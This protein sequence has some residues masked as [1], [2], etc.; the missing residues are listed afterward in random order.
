[1]KDKN[2]TTSQADITTETPSDAVHP[3]PKKPK[4]ATGPVALTIIAAI[5]LGGGAMWYVQKNQDSLSQHYGSQLSLVVEQSK[6]NE[7]ATQHA[8]NLMKNQAQQIVQLRQEL[9]Q[10]KD[11]IDDLSVALQTISE[12]GSDLMLL[13]DVE[14]LVILAQQQLLIGGNL[15]NAIV[16]LET[17]Q[18]RLAQ[19]DRQSLALLMQT[20][21]GDLD[22]LRTAQVVDVSTLTVQLDRLGNLL[23]KA[24]LYVPDAK[25][26][27]VNGEIESNTLT[28]PAATPDTETTAEQEQP[29]WKRTLSGAVDLTQ[30]G[31]QTISQDLGQFVSVRRVDDSA[32]LLMSPD[33]AER[34]RDSLSLRITMAQLALMTKQPKIWQDEMARI[35]EAI[36][37]RFDPSLAMTQRALSLAT[38][39]ADTEI[40][41]KLPTIDNTLAAIERLKQADQ[42]ELTAPEDLTASPTTE[43]TETSSNGAEE[44]QGSSPESTP[45]SAPESTDKE[46]TAVESRDM[47][48]DTVKP[49]EEAFTTSSFVVSKQAA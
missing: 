12:S 44:T 1:M 11:Q 20:M 5:V 9:A 22:R 47:P 8:L 28:E 24:P 7:Q 23:S 25:N 36:E 16:S 13:N 34:F 40:D 18:A 26:D 17:A 3:A 46:S 30:Q 27:S 21:N 15:A 45:P 6:K 29:W 19:A 49:T 2:D 43:E 48:S 31:W 10:T 4:G 41:M 37:Q 14:Q 38:Q 42:S 39:L 32:A 33:Q 35:V